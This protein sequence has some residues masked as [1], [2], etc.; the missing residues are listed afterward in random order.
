MVRALLLM[1]SDPFRT[2]P[3]QE[4]LRRAVEKLELLLVMDYLPSEAVR[5]AQI[6]LPTRTQFEMESSFVNQEGRV[7][8]ASSAHRG[9]IPISQISAGGHPPRLFRS[10]VPGNEPE[11]AW[12]A[13]AQLANAMS[14]GGRERLPLSRGELWNWISKEHIAFSDVP[15]ADQLSHAFRVDLGQGKETPFSSNG[16]TPSEKR[17]PGDGELE[18][19]V[20]DWTFGTEELSNY[21]KFIQ[22]VEQEPCLLMHPKDASRTGLKDKERIT[23][24]LDRGP[25][26]VELRVVDNVAPGVIILPKHRR[27]PWQKMERQPLKVGVDR[28]RK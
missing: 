23:L 3:D 9:G 21:S 17:R 11:P 4:R 13:L 14:L 22:Q 10:D 27:L 25:L 20:A 8:F 24:H 19:L 16:R 5:L 12:V 15:F 7:Q 26:A 6:L 2:F 28:I 1:E 18:L